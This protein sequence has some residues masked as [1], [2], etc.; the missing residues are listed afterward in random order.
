MN[1]KKIK[2]LKIFYP[3]HEWGKHN[4]GGDY[5]SSV[6]YSRSSP[7]EPFFEVSYWC[8]GSVAFDWCRT[9]GIFQSCRSCNEYDLE[10][11]RCLADPVLVPESQ[12]LKALECL[13]ERDEITV[14]YF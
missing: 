13:D 2:Y 8:S 5:A 12:V 3:P 1:E 11:G 4:D 6:K 9:Y 14:E 10:E 7:D